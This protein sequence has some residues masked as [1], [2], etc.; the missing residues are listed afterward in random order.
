M[1]AVL[2]DAP[3]LHDVDSV[4]VDDL[5]DAVGDDDY[6]AVALYR[7]ER[8]FDLLGGDGVERGGGFVEEHYRGVFEEHARDGD[9]LLLAAGE[10]LRR[11]V[12]PLGQGGDL[13]VEVGASCGL[14]HLGRRGFG[15]AVADVLEDRAVEDV[16]LLEHQTDVVPQRLGVVIGQRD[17]V[18]Q[19]LAA[20][21]GVEFVEQVDEGAFAR[22]RE[23]HQSGDL[24]RADVH[25]Y[26]EQRRFG[27]VGVGEVDSAQGEMS[28]DTLGAVI[29]RRFD[30]A[31][32][33]QGV[34]E[35]LGVDQCV[36][37]LVVDTVELADG[38]RD[39]AEKHD[40]EHDRADGHA[41]RKHEVGR[42][43]DYD[44]DADLLDETFEAVESEVDV[45]RLHLGL[46]QVV[47]KAQL[48]L[49]FEVFAR[50]RLYDRDRVENAQDAL[51]FGLPQV[52]DVAAAAFEFAGL[53]GTRP[54]VDRHYAKAHETHPDVGLEH[55]HQGHHRTCHQRQDVDEEV[56]HETRQ[57]LD[58][59]VDARLELARAVAARGEERQ[60]VGHNLLDDRLGKVARDENSQLLAVPLLAVL[61]DGVDE[62]LADEDRG[63]GHEHR[64][65]LLKPFVGVQ[66]GGYL[67]DGV[68][69]YPR[70]DLRGER[71]DERER[72]RQ[73][74]KPV[75]GSDEDGD[76]FEQRS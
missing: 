62:F 6:R 57:A 33:V 64:Q 73:Y 69:E 30:L 14:F 53:G 36:V 71:A 40:V 7:V 46:C 70:V 61:E 72:E 63:D 76:V 49:R 26:V 22:P 5:R 4:A 43:D 42:Q 24:A 12:V 59:A 52:A 58:A 31:V 16:V 48:L 21:G 8:G 25:F 27:V 9:P 44:D 20:V 34:E 10:V 18:E 35:G 23:A 60:A 38:R 11:G 29:A 41:A 54:E 13:V 50:E 67:V 51:R 65:A 56:L 55:H 1:G 37:Y 45:A 68:A 15:I 39:I 28:F 19:Y 17:A 74:D 3:L 75:V 47:L 66:K 32:G 2:N